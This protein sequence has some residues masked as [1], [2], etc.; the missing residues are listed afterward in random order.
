MKKSTVRKLIAQPVA[1]L[2]SYSRLGS[3]PIVHSLDGIRQP[4]VE[5]DLRSWRVLMDDVDQ[6]LE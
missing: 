4:L 5:A 1:F 2:R 6:F 3:T